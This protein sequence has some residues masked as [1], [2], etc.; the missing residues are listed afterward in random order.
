MGPDGRDHTGQGRGKGASEEAMQG[1]GWGVSGKDVGGSRRGLRAVGSGAAKGGR[2]SEGTARPPESF[3]QSGFQLD[4]PPIRVYKRAPLTLPSFWLVSTRPWIALWSLSESLLLT[5]LPPPL[6]S[7]LL[8]SS[9]RVCGHH[10]HRRTPLQLHHVPR[11]PPGVGLEGVPHAHD[12][13][14]VLWKQVWGAEGTMP[15]LRSSCAVARDGIFGAS[16]GM[17]ATPY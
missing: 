12:A 3:P 15:D 16:E 10:L 2:A 11:G 13:G 1:H 4:R 7:W 9:G 5:F 8:Q 17:A 6:I 14:F